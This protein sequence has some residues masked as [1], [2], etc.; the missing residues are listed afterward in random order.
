MLRAAHISIRRTDIYRIGSVDG[1]RAARRYVCA[2]LVIMWVGCASRARNGFSRVLYGRY[3]EP[4]Q[5]RRRRT[6]T[7]PHRN[8]ISTRLLPVSIAAHTLA[9][10]R[11]CVCVCSGRLGLTLTR[12]ATLYQI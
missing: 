1:E 5:Q 3:P 7:P 8:A 12:R 9:R 6:E 4:I 11:V 10:A 2:R